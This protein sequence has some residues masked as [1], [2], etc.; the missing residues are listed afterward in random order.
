MWFVF[1]CVIRV[2]CLCCVCGC[3]RASG[4]VVVCVCVVIYVNHIILFMICS[5]LNGNIM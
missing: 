3:R 1:D 2:F 4:S 5:L